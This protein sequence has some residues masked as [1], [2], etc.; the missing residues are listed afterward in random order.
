VNLGSS[1]DSGDA[2]PADSTG[3][4]GSGSAMIGGFGLG[5]NS[6]R[7]R[8]GNGKR[9][10]RLGLPDGLGGGDGDLWRGRTLASA[11]IS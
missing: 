9:I 7:Y 6:S 5:G 11:S 1:L 4:S 10:R 3:S 8:C 2:R